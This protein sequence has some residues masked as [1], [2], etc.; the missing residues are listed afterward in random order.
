MQQTRQAPG[1]G[2]V[3]RPACPGIAGPRG[4]CSQ[5]TRPGGSGPCRV[6][7]AA[8]RP[9]PCPRH[10]PC[11]GAWP[12]PREGPSRS[13]LQRAARSSPRPRVAGEA[14]ELLL[15][16]ARHPAAHEPWRAGKGRRHARHRGPSSEAQDGH[17]PPGRPAG[18]PAPESSNP[19]RPGVTWSGPPTPANMVPPA[20]GLPPCPAQRRPTPGKM[21]APEAAWNRL[22]VPWPASSATVALAAKHPAGPRRGGRAGLS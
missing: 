21:A 17:P 4:G 8:P 22:D 9:L 3:S 18:G 11:H 19:T 20:F 6:F 7:W 1:L 15:R 2:E 16:G 14:R 10:Q 13:R 12:G 5:A